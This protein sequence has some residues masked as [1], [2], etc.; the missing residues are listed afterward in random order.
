MP[1]REPSLPLRDIF[2]NIAD[3]ETYIEGMDFDAFRRDGKTVAAV[4]R[5]LQVISEAAVRLGEQG[6]VL[7][8]DIPW[9]Q[10]RGL[11]NWLRHQYDR[12]DLQKL[13]EMARDDLP[14]LK[15]AVQRVLN[16][17]AC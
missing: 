11:G 7:C 5:K 8:P 16:S 1:F 12:I 9:P 17:Q 14:V 13:W 4:E 10:I 3:I 2:G 6:P 15:A